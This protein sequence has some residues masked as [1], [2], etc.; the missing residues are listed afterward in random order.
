MTLINE[1]VKRVASRNKKTTD[2]NVR[3]ANGIE[4]IFDIVVSMDGHVLSMGML[5]CIKNIHDYRPCSEEMEDIV[6]A[7]W[8]IAEGSTDTYEEAI[9]VITC[10][11]LEL[12]SEFSRFNTKGVEMDGFVKNRN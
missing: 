6:D 7:V 5:D 9:G 1:I 10:V 4:G 8:R 2:K 11:Q 12:Q 3:I